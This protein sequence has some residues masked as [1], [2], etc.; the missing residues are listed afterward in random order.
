MDA[1]GNQEGV[2]KID[3]DDAGSCEGDFDGN[4]AVNVGDLLIFNS[5]FGCTSACGAPDLDGNGAV[6]VG[7]L[8][9]FNS[10]FGSVCP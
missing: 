4:G 10:L 1:P 3:V 8:L 5:A 7:D 2:F 9:L 6:N